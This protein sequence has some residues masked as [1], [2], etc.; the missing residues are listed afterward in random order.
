MQRDAEGR[1]KGE[2]AKLVGRAW[3]T[4]NKRRNVLNVIFTWPC[5]ACII[6][7]HP[8]LCSYIGG[9]SAFDFEFTSTMSL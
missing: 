8:S 1:T 5:V 9:A 3:W 6:S 4:N 7:I 2:E